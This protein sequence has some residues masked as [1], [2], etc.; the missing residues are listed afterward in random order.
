MLSVWK[1]IDNS[2]Y[3]ISIQSKA[4]EQFVFVFYIKQIAKIKYRLPV[5]VFI[6]QFNLSHKLGLLSTHFKLDL[7]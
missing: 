6:F 2:F 3:S 4:S 1:Y 5:F 7:M